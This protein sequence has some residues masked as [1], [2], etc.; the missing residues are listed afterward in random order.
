MKTKSELFLYH[1][2]WPAESPLQ[3]VWRNLTRSFEAWAYQ[4]SGEGACLRQAQTLEAGGW[5]ESAPAPDGRGRLFR[6]TP[7]GCLRAIGGCLP[8]DFW[9]RPW[10]G[11][12]RTVVFDFPES[13]RTLRNELRRDLRA[14]R[15]GCLQGGMWI[16]PHPLEPHVARLRERAGTCGSITF[17]EGRPCCGDQPSGIAAKAWDL[18]RLHELHQEHLAHLA[19]LPR[20]GGP[21]TRDQLRQWGRTERSLWEQCLAHDPLLPRELWPDDYLGETAW[22]E[23]LK[24]LNLAGKTADPAP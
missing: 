12:W 19:R 18:A 9:D 21:E 8:T 15:F 23:R 14:T 4:G 3:P 11:L 6:L 17:F 7:A 2:L 24:A 10:D 13:R 22:I 16:S 1:S 20:A 5:L